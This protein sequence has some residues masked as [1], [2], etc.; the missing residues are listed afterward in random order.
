MPNNNS[1]TL[2]PRPAR[3]ILYSFSIIQHNS[4]V[5]WDVCLSLMNSLSQLSSPPMIV[6]LQDPRLRRGQLPSF[7]TYKCFHPPLART[8]VAFYVHLHLLNSVSLLPVTSTRSDLL[9]IDIFAPGGFFE[10]QFARFRVTNAYT[11]PSTLSPFALSPHLPCSRIT[12]SRP[13]W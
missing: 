11:S 2:S 6:A 9:S 13:W 10:L 4:L 12:L 8:R 3:V 1:S 7:S 5:S